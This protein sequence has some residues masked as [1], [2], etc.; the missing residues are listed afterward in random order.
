MAAGTT[1]F[2][3]N[4]DSNSVATGATQITSTGYNNHSVQI[5][6][7]EAKV[8][9]NSSAVTTSHD[10]KLSGVT[11][12]DKAVSKT[13][14]ETLTNKVLSDSTT[15]FGN[16][17]D[18]TK[19]LKMSLG[20]ATTAKTMTIVSSHTNDRTITLP[21]ATDTLV[22]KNTTDTLTNKTLTSPVIQTGLTATGLI[23]NTMLSTS[24]GEL[25]G[26]WT[27]WSPSY[28]NLTAG[29]GVLDYARYTVRGKTVHAKWR[30]TL[31]TTSSIGGNVTISLPV[32]MSSDFDDVGDVLDGA[33][34][35]LDAGTNWYH[36]FVRWSAAGIV[37]LSPMNASGTYT[38]ATTMSATVPFTFGST[39]SLGFSIT[40]EAA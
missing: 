29:N 39:D 9:V 38:L 12:S 26:A 5:E 4:L 24:A 6:A 3:T 28:V 20:G 7:L 25:G 11:G 40:Y 8:G 14:T 31:G 34:F 1:N 10:Y 19:A 21:N 2:P 15:T 13:G 36:G 37:F 35:F 23:T 22:G 17:S 27:T 18:T 32:N 16:V 33:A 30:F